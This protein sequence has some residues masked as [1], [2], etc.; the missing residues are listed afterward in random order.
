MSDLRESFRRQAE[1]LG[2]EERLQACPLPEPILVEADALERVPAYV[3]GQGWRKAAIACDERTAAAAGRRLQR[4]LEQAGIDAFVAVI[5]ADAAGD[6]VADEAS[7][8]ELLLAAK[9]AGADVLFAAGAGTIHD[10]TRFAAYALGIPFVSVPTAAS[11]D[12]FT[13]LGAPL[14][15]RGV[16]TT[17]A[18]VGPAAVFA[19][20]GLLQAAPAPLA[21]AGFGD[22]LGKLT[23]LA[24][25][26]IE[27]LLSGGAQG[28]WSAGVAALSGG[29]LRRSIEQADRLRG[30][31]AAGGAQAKQGGAV[32]IGQ[33]EAGQDGAVDGAQAEVEQGG[34]DD[35]TEAGRGGAVESVQAEAERDGAASGVE[36][37]AEALIESGLA[38]LLLGASH[39]A[40]GAEHHLSHYWEMELHRAGARP[41]LHGAKVGAACAVIADYYRAIVAAASGAPSVKSEPA[42]P[43][44]ASLPPVSAEAASRVAAAAGPAWSE[45]ERIVGSLP[46][47]E[48]IRELLALAGGPGSPAELG[49]SDAQ[50]ERALLEAD[51]VR[52]G[53]L[54]LLRAYN[55]ELRKLG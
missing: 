33:A 51:R 48:R 22:M 40:S 45:I 37:L 35:C 31:E 43:T 6:V 3:A 4:L 10:L 36:T 42:A 24:D 55:E 26:R 32:V 53:R 15:L 29:A 25:W 54:T 13:S 47:G 16:K 41:L 27:H 2:L 19:D 23:S 9:P 20:I 38:M 8:M 28:G 12:G 49:L 44:Y 14:L 1:A 7:L 52:P 50:V 5:A 18:A 11:V 17:V 34:A 21:A 30:G 46:S 39:P